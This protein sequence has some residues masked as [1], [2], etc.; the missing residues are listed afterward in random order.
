MEIP[1]WDPII[2]KKSD[3]SAYGSEKWLWSRV[4]H[5]FLSYFKSCDLDFAPFSRKNAKTVRIVIILFKA[6]LKGGGFK[7]HREKKGILIVNPA[8][9]AGFIRIFFGV[10][11]PQLVG[12]G[13]LQDWWRKRYS[14]SENLLVILQYPPNDGR[15]IQHTSPFYPSWFDLFAICDKLIF[16]S[17]D[18]DLYRLD[19]KMEFLAIRTCSLSF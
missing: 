6:L 12:V 17:V 10:N 2:K 13:K 16:I 15:R 3:D 19:I 4:R 7:T 11:D 1:S 5:F 8:L 9:L 14:H 18:V